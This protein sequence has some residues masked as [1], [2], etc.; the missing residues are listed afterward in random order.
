M[1]EVGRGT[2]RKEEGKKRPS[3][4]QIN[5]AKTCTHKPHLVTGPPR[6]CEGPWGA[7][8]VLNGVTCQQHRGFYNR[9]APRGSELR[10]PRL[11]SGAHPLTS[12]SCLPATKLQQPLSS[13]QDGAVS[14]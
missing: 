9:T 4:K 10:A 7:C 5:S 8:R 11:S 3:H 2:R 14:R 6:G 13:P 12:P 1:G